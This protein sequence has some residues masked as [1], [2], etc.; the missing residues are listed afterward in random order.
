MKLFIAGITLLYALT[1]PVS[2]AQAQETE[3]RITF[4]NFL[5]GELRVAFLGIDLSEAK[6]IGDE[7]DWPGVDF[8]KSINPAW[9]N[10]LAYDLRKYRILPRALRL[11]SESVEYYHNICT[12]HNNELTF[13]D[14]I[15]PVWQ[16]EGLN[17]DKIQLTLNTYDFAGLTGVGLMILIESFDAKNKIGR[18]TFTFL[19]L[20][21]HKIIYSEK[22]SG[23][24]G[25][26]GPR[27][28][29]VET[30]HDVI[31]QVQEIKY[32][33]WKKEYLR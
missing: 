26:T 5:S 25:G 10:L 4:K 7:I 32:K 20:D 19:D 18:M 17:D 27:K 12:I 15:V 3:N 8:I 22:M 14:A 31:S 2:P 21:T 33:E 11:K 28:Y 30:V 13:K 1:Y 23:F 16:S 6:F 24:P 29:W 9:N